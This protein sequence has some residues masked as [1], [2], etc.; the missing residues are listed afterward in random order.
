MG[1]QASTLW[2]ADRAAW[3]PIGLRY[4]P[5]HAPLSLAWESG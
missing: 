5:W 2:Y 1:P 4:L 3:W